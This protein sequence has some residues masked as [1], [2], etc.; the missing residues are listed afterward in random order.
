MHEIAFAFA[1]CWRAFVSFDRTQL[2]ANWLF[3][4]PELPLAGDFFHSMPP[5]AA[6]ISSFAAGMMLLKSYLGSGLLAVP[7]AFDCGGL[8][9]SIVGIVLLAA[10]SNHTLKMMI[11]LKGEVRTRV[12]YGAAD[13]KMG[14]IVVHRRVATD[15]ATAVADD[16]S[17]AGA[18]TC[19]SKA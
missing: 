13:E 15:G 10:I 9:A 16:E 1:N 8:E 5:A 18:A 6:R 3:S 4:E 19:H 17:E 14:G 12:R 2:F 7:Y 11:K